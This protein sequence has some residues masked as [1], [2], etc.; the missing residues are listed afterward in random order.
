MFVP[1]LECCRCVLQFLV[2][3]L[4]IKSNRINLSLNQIRM[5]RV[6]FLLHRW[7]HP[8]MLTLQM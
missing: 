3:Y 4:R 7:Y 6:K 1:H 2:L 5:G 8:G